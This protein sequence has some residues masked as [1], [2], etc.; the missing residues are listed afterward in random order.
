MKDLAIVHRHY[1]QTWVLSKTIYRQ[2]TVTIITPWS[3]ILPSFFSRMKND[4][5]L[6]HRHYNQTL[7]FLSLF[8]FVSF[9]F[10]VSASSENVAIGRK[11]ISS[12]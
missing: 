12:L 11:L 10:I 2:G 7:V 1:N 5:P 3:S 9:Y 4:L 6:V 8:L